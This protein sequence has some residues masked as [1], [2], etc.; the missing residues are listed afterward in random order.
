VGAKMAALGG[1][2]QVVSITHLPQVA[3]AA[4]CH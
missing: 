3:A 4:H 2:H 1:Q